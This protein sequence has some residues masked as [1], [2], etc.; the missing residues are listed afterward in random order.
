MKEIT[1]PAPINIIRHTLEA[2]AMQSIRT[3][4]VLTTEKLNIRYL[5]ITISAPSQITKL[6]PRSRSKVTAAIV[7]RI[8]NVDCNL[9][10]RTRLV[11]MEGR[12]EN[13][14]ADILSAKSTV[15][16]SAIPVN[17]RDNV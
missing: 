2:E 7:L 14:W 6:A 13:G 16:I 8:L 11:V 5:S 17:D 4:L 12:Y 10:N 15:D 1:T 3:H 9:G